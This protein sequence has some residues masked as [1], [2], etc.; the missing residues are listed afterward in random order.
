MKAIDLTLSAPK[1]VSPLWAFG[2]DEMASEVSIAMV[3]AATTGLDF[4]ERH[5]AVAPFR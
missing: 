1:S 5:A 2:G 3:E 4:M